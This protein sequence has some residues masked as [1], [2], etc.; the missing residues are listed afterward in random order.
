MARPCV[1]RFYFVVNSSATKYVGAAM[2]RVVVSALVLCGV[3]AAVVVGVDGQ[4][5]SASDDSF[6][7]VVPARVFDTRSDGS[8][9][10]GSQ[11]RL[12]R[13]TAGQVSPVQIGGRAGVP[14][15]AEAVVVNV[16][17]INPTQAGFVTVYPC[18]VKRP[19]ASTLNYAAGTVVANGATVKIGDGGKVCVYTHRAMDLVVDVTGYHRS[20]A[21]FA[22]VVPAR[23][24]ET[25]PD[26]STVD[27]LL[28]RVGRRE[29][30]Q[31]SQVQIGGRAG[32]PLD[33][34]G[35]VVNVTAINPDGPGFVTVDNCNRSDA[36]TLNHVAGAVVANSAAIRMGTSL[37][38]GKICVYTHRATDLVVDVTGYFPAGSLF[39]G[40]PS[41]RVFETRAGGSTVD[42]EQQGVGRRKAGQ[43]TK[44]QIG[45][46]ALVQ[47]YAEAVVVNVTAINP[48]GPG[49][50]TVYPCGVKRP[51]ASTLNYAAG[52]VVANGATVKIGDGAKVCVYTHREMDLV[53]DV[54]GY[55]RPAV[56][57]A[58]PFSALT[59]GERHTCGLQ[60]DR[61]A[62]CWGFNGGVVAPMGTFTALA[63]GSRYTCGLRSE[64]TPVCWGDSPAAPPAGTFTALAAGRSF[65]CGLRSNGTPNCWGYL[66]G[67]VFPPAG[68]FTTLTAG[69]GHVCGLRSDGTAACWGDNDEGQGT[70]PAGA[71]TAISAGGGHTCGLRSDGTATCWG[72]NIIGAATPPSG[73]FTAIS[74]GGAHTCGLRSDG[75]GTCWGDNSSGIATAPSGTFTAISAGSEHTCGLRP[76]GAATCWGA[77]YGGEATP[78][79]TR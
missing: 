71:F 26:G 48:D 64:G 49:F 77:N 15:N 74:A 1:A 56:V 57:L 59:A 34:V 27:G 24:F 25:R 62:I 39:T 13:R 36:S 6:T 32:V 65:V 78:P 22:G 44:V 41:R 51:T 67:Q 21:S 12:G 52:T 23:V 5:V 33:A 20:R 69:S 55:Y 29:S 42:G 70:P 76:T 40:V 2:R 63:A 58:R 38:G 19:T 66:R 35:V 75:T 73:T 16:T 53:V 72:N 68:T 28:Q 37:T 79:G 47:A 17:A 8:T 61:T 43:E 9:V 50:V 54:T 3:V 11:Q 30:A 46:R 10:D 7:G 60:T 45:G 18:G 14:A 31:I 4:P